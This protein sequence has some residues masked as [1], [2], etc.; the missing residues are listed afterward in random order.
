M[1]ILSIVLLFVSL[2]VFVLSSV[3]TATRKRGEKLI[4]FTVWLFI[5]IL[6]YLA[7]TGLGL[8]KDAQ[9]SG[10]DVILIIPDAVVK[11]LQHFTMNIAPSDFITAN[12]EV[13]SNTVIRAVF[14]IL[15]S[16]YFIASPATGG[17]I[18]FN[19]ACEIFPDLKFSWDNHSTKFIFSE[20]NE[21]TLT[22]A[23]SLKKKHDEARRK[24]DSESAENRYLYDVSITF[25][26]AAPSGEG[27]TVFAEYSERAKNIGANL[28]KKDFK[29]LAVKRPAGFA[30]LLKRIF[31]FGRVR[32][33]TTLTYFLFGKN[34]AENIKDAIFLADGAENVKKS[35]AKFDKVQLHVLSNNDDADEII[36]HSFKSKNLS[37]VTVQ[38]VR[39][40][41]NMVYNLLD[42]KYSLFYS[43]LGW[44]N[45]TAENA[46]KRAMSDLSVVVIG[47]GGI[48]KQFIKAAYWCGQTLDASAKL[49][50]RAFKITVISD[51]ATVVENQLKFDMPQ[52]FEGDETYGKMEFK[53][54]SF[55]T[56]DFFADFENCLNADYVLV[57]LGNDD[58]NMRAAR[59]VARRL[60]VANEH[61]NKRPVINFVIENE[62]L[63]TALRIEENIA[64]TERKNSGN[65]GGAILNPFGCLTERFDYNNVFLS[66]LENLAFVMDSAYGG[67]AN[68]TW[69]AFVS[70]S[71]GRK[72]SMATAVHYKY[73]LASIG[74][75]QSEDEWLNFENSQVLLK[76]KNRLDVELCRNKLHY[77]EHIRWNAYM[78][79]EGYRC[80]S[81]DQF[82]NMA[83][84]YLPYE[85]K[86]VP[87]KFLSQKA[88]NHKLHSC[89][90]PC[91]DLGITLNTADFEQAKAQAN[92]F[93][94]AIPTTQ[95]LGEWLNGFV[96]SLSL[97]NA[98]GTAKALDEL[99]GLS[100]IISA[101]KGKNVDY[102]DYDFTMAASVY[103]SSVS[104]KIMDFYKAKDDGSIKLY[105]KMLY[106]ALKAYQ[107]D[108]VEKVTAQYLKK[109]GDI[110]YVHVGAG[111]GLDY[112]LVDQAG[113]VGL[114]VYETSKI[115]KLGNY[116]W[117][118]EQAAY[119]E[120]LPT[121]LAEDRAEYFQAS[122]YYPQPINTYGIELGAEV[123][124]LAEII[125]KNTHEVWATGKI[126]QGWKY[127]KKHKERRKQT[128]KLIPYEELS[129]SE[130]DYDRRTSQETLRLIK[131]LGFD[132]VKVENSE[133]NPENK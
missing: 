23:E 119:V 50:K 16:I 29:S 65:V 26:N 83:F 59:W 131:K 107:K 66:Q 127:G 92:A 126:A 117:S 11:A 111:A 18:I 30:Y 79:S 123:D 6:L 81:V 105:C 36:S 68:K 99:D 112:V 103:L 78:I 9:Y 77:I 118:S 3:V 41:S 13:Y 132:I 4:F 88:V 110:T 120:S 122:K 7:S 56:N 1:E 15:S 128:P 109:K 24:Y 64:S 76:I 54:H 53:N 22:L 48:G 69:T 95:N 101:Y 31:S 21:Y 113:K 39:E 10:W 74:V 28:L 62:D 61:S 102:K 100:L 5:A 85:N 86:V 116:Y 115:Y 97:K 72:S 37:N 27:D 130:K 124:A 51:N 35:W 98:D 93:I 89:I 96:Q 133:E 17:M 57:A 125:A 33:S 14:F 52:A 44:Q 121:A 55:G 104:R 46:S 38:V 73:K 87:T 47:C 20:L 108:G 106:D 67:N 129:E 58:L 75:I 45:G 80:P 32:K 70:D 60:N 8:L 84:G 94:T 12:A 34:E 91:N 90:L 40:Y 82:L 71:Y 42:S 49:N 2:G 63:C 19:L 43:Q 25:T 114:Y